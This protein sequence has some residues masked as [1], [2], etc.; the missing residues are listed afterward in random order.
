KQIKLRLNTKQ[1]AILTGWLW[2]LTGVWNWAVRK[3]ELDAKDKIFD[4]ANDFQNLLANHGEKMGIPSHALQG[5]LS[6]A[7]ASWARCFKKLA[8][9]PRLKG[10]RNKLN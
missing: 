1:D 9:K 7:H 6:Q 2:N 8:K 4:G 5:L 3:I 10:K